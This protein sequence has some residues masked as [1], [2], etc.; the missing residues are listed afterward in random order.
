M[1][2]TKCADAVQALYGASYIMIVSLG[3]YLDAL[4]GCLKAI[5]RQMVY[6]RTLMSS[7]PMTFQS[8]LAVITLHVSREQAQSENK[9][10]GLAHGVGCRVCCL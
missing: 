2:A 8:V 4:Y 6:S 10:P 9:A 3:A 7:S 5:P 1:P